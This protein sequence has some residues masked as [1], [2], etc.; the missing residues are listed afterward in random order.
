MIVGAITGGI[1]SGKS[2]VLK[3][4]ESFPHLE[5]IQADELAK[6]IYDPENPCFQEVVE[7][8]GEKILT[9]EGSVDKKKVSEMV[10]SDPS[11]LKKLEQISHPYVK[12]RIEG[13][14]ECQKEKNTH[15]T[16]V[17]IPLL[18]QSSTIELDIFD[19][20][21]LVKSTK[22][23][24]LKRLVNRDGVSVEEAE[25]RIELQ[26][27]PDSARENSDYVI[28]AGGSLEKTRKQA[29]DLIRELLD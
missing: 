8:F 15:M 11:L 19:L 13:I 27:L 3:E 25:K 17:E 10:F 23:D 20:V 28:D 16:L 5:A 7:L 14:L 22:E 4:V 12:G 6:E 1:A 29:R 24:Q 26:R 9:D 21:I 18:F 2:E